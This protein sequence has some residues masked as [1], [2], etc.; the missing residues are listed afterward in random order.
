MR[1]PKDSVEIEITKNNDEIHIDHI[2]QEP[3]QWQQIHTRAEIEREILERNKRHLQ[4][5]YYEESPPSNPEMQELF[6]DYGCGPNSDKILNGELTHE[7]DKFSE[8]IRR[9][10]QNLKRTP[11]E[12]SLPMID[13]WITAQEFRECYKSVREQT[14]SSL[15][16]LNYTLWKCISDN[17]EMCE[18]M[19]I[20]MSLPFVYGFVNTRWTKALD[21]MLEKVKGL[22]QIHRLRIIGL[23][24]ADFN[25]ALKFLFAKKLMKNAEMTDLCHEQWAR[26]NRTAMDPALR[27]V[28]GFEYSRIMYVTITLLA[29]DM[30]A[31]FDRMVPDISSIIARKYGMSKNVM[32]ARNQIIEQMQHHIRTSHG[33]S[34]EYYT[35]QPG[36]KRLAGE[37]QGKGD[38]ATLFALESLTI[39]NTHKEMATGIELQHVSDPTIK[40]TKNNDAFVDDTDGS[41]SIKGRNFRE[42][43]KIVMKGT[44][45]NGQ[46]WTDLVDATGGAIAHHKTILQAACYDDSHPP[47]LKPTPDTQISLRDRYGVP[48]KI[49]NVAVSCPIKGLGCHIAVDASMH[50]SSKHEYEVRLEQCRS[51]AKRCS[52]A[53]LTPDEAYMIMRPRVMPS[54]GY[55]AAVTRFTPK[56]CQKINSAINQVLLPKVKINRKTPL[57]VIYAPLKLGGL[58]WPS[59][60]VKQDTDSILTLI[61]HMRQNTTMA[62]DIKVT[63]SAWQLV[64]GLCTPFLEPTNENLNFLGPG[65]IH[66]MRQRLQHMKGKIWLEH[67]WT[68]TTTRLNDTSIMSTLL[69]LNLPNSVLR[70]IN[71]VR[72]FLHVITISDLADITGAKIPGMRFTGKWQAQSRLTWPDIPTPPRNLISLFRSCIKKAYATKSPSKNT[73]SDMTLDKHLGPWNSQTGHIDYDAYRTHTQIFIRHRDQFNIFHA[74]HPQY[75]TYSHTTTDIPDTAHPTS[76]HIS[77]GRVYSHHPYSRS[78]RPKQTQPQRNEIIFASDTE[79]HSCSDGSVNITDGSRA[80]AYILHTGTKTIMGSMNFPTSDYSTSYRSELEGILLLTQAIND[81]N[82]PQ[83]D[84]ACDNMKAIMKVEKE[85]INPTRLLDSEADL[86]L[87]IQELRS[88][89][90]T[91]S[92]LTWMRGHSDDTEHYDKLTTKQQTQVDTDNLAKTSR[93]KEPV[94]FQTPYP[95]SKA[96]LIINNKWITTSYHEQIHEAV[97]HERHK[98]YFLGRHPHLQSPDYYSIN[99]RGIGIARKRQKHTHTARI[100][101]YMNGWLNVGHQ[102]D[103][104]G[105]DGQCPCCGAQDETQLHLFHCQ[106]ADMRRTRTL[107]LTTMTEH[108]ISKGLPSKVL[109]PFVALIRSFVSNTTNPPSI[110]DR[111]PHMETTI[112]QQEQIG[113][114]ATLRGYLC[115]GWLKDIQKYTTSHVDRKCKAMFISLWDCLFL[116]VWEQ[117]NNILHV[118]NNIVTVTEHKT[119]DAELLD[120]KLHHRDRF[121]HYTQYHLTSFTQHD[122]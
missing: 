15:S 116:P 92:T 71:Y 74:T 56:Q 117:R 8:P 2:S 97:V 46:L 14:S 12:Q 83:Q 98:Q 82:P 52:R 80:A 26:S 54:V 73:L 11:S 28:L 84:Q 65:W 101:K 5:V 23:L 107:A 70:K 24:E 94:T 100:T 88:K 47:N 6:D 86:I 41:K 35:H 60:E 37:I 21:V 36:D 58:N 120:W 114:E 106:N 33:E 87:A 72:L 85:I 110:A 4:Q 77:E 10:L 108:L 112:R 9:W 113:P 29:N 51:I 95:G 49:Q 30:T 17:D 93:T 18:Y 103:K 105:Q 79:P 16:G 22:R 91:P 34:A 27:K 59:F 57:A 115:K 111:F 109:Q 96:M 62:T 69:K 121:F 39:L 61:K 38:V 102:K 44:E 67:Q 13:G 31:C 76:A 63:L 90:P 42:C 64:S 25:T 78:T 1:N 48:T 45:E 3:A 81:H 50:G 7:L 32:R 89:T 99:F 118:P 40:I 68:P 20:M 119:L 53:Q 55:S 75:F 66:H 122:L 19:S 104:M 43:E